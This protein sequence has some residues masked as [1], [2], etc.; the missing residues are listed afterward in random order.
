[1]PF[2]Y[3][4]VSPLDHALLLPVTVSFVRNMTLMSGM[5]YFVLLAISVFQNAWVS[6]VVFYAGPEL[7][8]CQRRQEIFL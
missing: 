8:V 1:M 2:E 6:A 4:C 5:V 7:V 3:V